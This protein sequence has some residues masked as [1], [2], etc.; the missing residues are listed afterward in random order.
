MTIRVQCRNCGHRTRH[1]EFPIKRYPCERCGYAGPIKLEPRSNSKAWLEVIGLAVLT[2]A[3]FYG[4]Y[5]LA[6]MP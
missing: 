5:L 2:F 1:H 6:H 4:M 3:L